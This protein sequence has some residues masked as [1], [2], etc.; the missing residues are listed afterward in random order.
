[1]AVYAPKEIIRSASSGEVHALAE[2]ASIHDRQDQET[3]ILIGA[4]RGARVEAGVLQP[5]HSFP[6]HDQHSVTGDGV[7]QFAFYFVERDLVVLIDIQDRPSR[8][9]RRIFYATRGRVTH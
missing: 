2:F 6:L 4:N 5:F 7:V 9:L 8:L 3:S 1:M